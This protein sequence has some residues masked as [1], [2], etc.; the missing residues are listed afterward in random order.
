M[1]TRYC[2]YDKLALERSKVNMD[3]YLI[4]RQTL[5]QFID[6]LIKRKPLAASSAEELYSF[7]EDNIE[8]LDNEIAM[9]IFGQLSEEQ[10]AEIEHAIDSGED[11]PEY[12]QNLFARYGIN[13]EKTIA[14]TV[15]NFGKRFLEGAND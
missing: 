10:L 1:L 15:A 3:K 2:A 4:D 13:L 14:D 5:E 9:A 7:R 12:F 8:Q 6:E 11:T